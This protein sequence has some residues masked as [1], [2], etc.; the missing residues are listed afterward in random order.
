MLPLEESRILRCRFCNTPL[1][2]TFADLGLQPLCEKYLKSDQLNQMEPF[3]P[4]HVYFCE[5]CF[6]VQLE[7]AISP[8]EIYNEYAYFSSS[9]KGWMKH[10]EAYAENIS[11]KLGLNNKSQVIEIGSN[12]GYLLQFFARKGIP[13]LGV[14]PAAN[15]AEVA[16]EKGIPTV[17]DFFGV[18]PAKKLQKQDKQADLLVGNNILAQVPDINGFVKGLKTLLKP[19]G[20]IS[21][22]FHHVL[23]LIDN[24]QF[25]TISHERF[26]YLSLFSVEK[27]FT[28]HGLK[29]FDAEEF[30]THGGSLRIYACHNED[31]PKSE[32]LN[33]N[34]I[35][36]K[37]KADGLTKLEKY[38]LFYEKVKE[39][40]RN[41]LNILIKLRNKKKSIVGY[42]AHAEA[43]TLLNYCGIDS[44]FLDY[45]VDRNPAKQGKF[46][47]GVHLP[48]FHPNKI[49][50]TKP[51][52]ILILTWNIK[53]EIMNQISYIDNWGAKFIVPVPKAKLYNAN[54]TLTTVET[55]TE[56]EDK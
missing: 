23:N 8:Q 21:I 27:I 41:I 32:S 2:Y 5:N 43:H 34:A 47:A 46:L 12:D 4:L 42:G 40:K 56:E 3:Y 11:R 13:V 54:E 20:V 28:F 26:S 39:T 33:V 16:I 37:E 9:S 49:S 6:L 24:N 53:K 25:D 30:P 14:E 45:L 29:I 35:R 19:S 36:E 7:A 22:E 55:L 52:Y 38:S 1:H 17:I 51:D 15:I 31:I 48:I 18:E 50:E 44:D 10:I